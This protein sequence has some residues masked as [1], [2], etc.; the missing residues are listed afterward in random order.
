MQ[1]GL[2]EQT[3]AVLQ[4]RAM[5]ETEEDCDETALITDTISSN[6]ADATLTAMSASQHAEVLLV[7]EKLEEDVRMLTT[8]LEGVQ[9]E[10]HSMREDSNAL[11]L[12][13]SVAQ[14][15]VRRLSAELAVSQQLI[16]S[17][18]ASL[19][20]DHAAFDLSCTRLAEL[21]ATHDHLLSSVESLT[22]ERDAAVE[23]IRVLNVQLCEERSALAQ[24][25]RP[26]FTCDLST[27]TL[28]PTH[29]SSPCSTSKRSQIS[30][31]R[32]NL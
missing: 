8:Q 29:S 19:S 27:L 6:L 11:G 20:E 14:E 17:A 10:L 5:I 30:P 3:I 4:S 18:S 12:E 22:S 2:H 23:S 25:S 16:D 21:H 28:Y 31:A 9:K 32:K 26:L 1:I 15:E 24:V 7:R 13:L